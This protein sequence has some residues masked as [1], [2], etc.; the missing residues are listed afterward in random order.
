[1]KK[2]NF[3]KQ[4]REVSLK[5]KNKSGFTLAEVLI[6]LTIIGVVASMTI[7]FLTANVQKT[8][9]ETRFLQFYSN[10]NLAM[11]MS[12]IKN[13]ET[14]ELPRHDYTYQENLD[15]VRTNLLPYMQ[16]K[17]YKNCN[18]PNRYRRNAV[19][20]KLVNGDLFEFVVDYN[21]ADLLYF[22]FGEWQSIE[23]NKL[24]PK[25]VMAMQFS[26]RVRPND[27]TELKSN[28]FIEP[29]TY[30]WNGNVNDLYNNKEY[31]CTKGT[32]KFFCAKIIQM[33]GW[34]VP[35]KYPW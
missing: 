30:K 4:Q 23:N 9:F 34:K 19:C 24:A 25:R 22:P 12:Y 6:A 18:D 27:D 16:Y 8:R 10:I 32:K 33:N 13:G 35:N 28:D 17:T 20:V 2:N 7:S 29:Y 11:K 1:M 5:S 14:V 26:K 21:G 3:I 31:G 15:W